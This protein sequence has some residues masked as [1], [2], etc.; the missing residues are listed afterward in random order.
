MD[1]NA[2]SQP[3]SAPASRVDELEGQLATALAER[4]QYRQL[5]VEMLEHSRKLELG[6]FGQRSERW[7]GSDKQLSLD[8]LTALAPAMQPNEPVATTLVPSHTR[9][10]PTGRQIL[11]EALPRITVEVLPD[12]V[13]RA[14]LD[15]FE[16]IG[17]EVSETLE[18]RRS[19]IVVMRIVRPKFVARRVP[20]FT[21]DAATQAAAENTAEQDAAATQAAAENT[22][23]Q[24]AAAMVHEV[25]ATTPTTSSPKVLIGSLP[26]MPIPRCLAG[27]ALL[28]QTVVQRWED[29]LPL[30][31]LEG[32]F[33]REGVSLARS[34]L[35][36][37]HT[38]L[39][40]LCRPLVA[41]MKRDALQQPLLC[42]DA[43]GVLVQAK[44]KCRHA[45]F[46]VLVAPHRHV[47]FMYSRKHDSE[48]VDKLLGGYQ[49][50]L[51]ADAH[52]VY[53]HLYGDKITEV[54]CWAHARRYFFK[55]LNSDPLRARHALALIGKLFHIERDAAEKSA[56]DRA[57]IRKLKSSKVV[58][59]FFLWCEQEALRTLDQTPIHAAIRYANNQKEALRQFLRDVRLPLDN[60]ISE[61]ALRRQAV[62][63]KNWL[64]VGSDEGGESNAIFVSLL[65]SAKLQGIEPTAYLRDLFFI[66]PL[67]SQTRLLELSPMLW[68]ETLEKAETQKLLAANHYRTALLKLE[69]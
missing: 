64:F 13:Q 63:R 58:D 20:Q 45:H 11:P 8:I 43:T 27:P 56:K 42:T 65:A 25:A 61:R 35:C 32:I 1:V 14:G 55:A 26:E 36:G 4:D 28:A 66:L 24:D 59:E 33:A 51:L 38:Q 49:G 9:H 22:A 6:I 18:Y 15:A 62:G 67:W 40:Q 68:K 44:E 57:A 46:W 69:R 39:A 2:S 31:R 19:S 10:K 23:E 53:D 12:E 47:L 16:R 34:T 29:S 50:Y 7:P 37:W 5:Y 17:E 21:Q 52:S 54:G 30:N 60:N 41:A 3:G 48:T